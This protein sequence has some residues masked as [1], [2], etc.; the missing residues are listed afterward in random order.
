MSLPGQATEEAIA[1]VSTDAGRSL[2]RGMAKLGNAALGPW[3][4]RREAKAA[5]AKLAIETKG[6]IEAQQAVVE[7][8]RKYELE[9]TEHLGLLERRAQRLRVELAREQENLENIQRKALEFTESDPDSI[10]AQEI[11]EDWLF[12]YAAFAQRVSD[13][14]VQLLWARVLSSAAIKGR[15]QLS[16]QALQ[17]LSLFDKGAAVDFQKFTFV[18]A[19]M[20]FFPVIDSRYQ[21][22]P[23]QIDLS[24]LADLG[25]IERN[26]SSSAYRFKDFMM[27]IGTNNLGL[28]LFKDRVVLTKRGADIATAVFRRSEFNPGDHVIDEY[29]RILVQRE[30]RNNKAVTIFLPG[31]GNPWPSAFVITEGENSATSADWQS[32]ERYLTASSKLRTLLEWAGQHYKIKAS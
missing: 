14:D 29:L 13:E 16:A 11:D 27:E 21:N 5:A 18:I 10:A 17:T 25:V 3:M 24:A 22:D 32:D 26:T 7:A 1:N 8:R 31:D 9:E 12:Q 2:V 20:G 28:Q 19:H 15:S 6:K 30:V 23:Q 4:A